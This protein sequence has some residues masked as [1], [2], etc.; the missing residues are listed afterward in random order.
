MP[1]VSF[2]FDDTLDQE[3]V[4]HYALQLM[5]RGV[6][7]WIVTARLDDDNV[8]KEFGEKIGNHDVIPPWAGNDDI[9]AQADAMGIPKNR[10]VFTNL[11]GKG[12]F[13]KRHPDFAW[14]LDDSSKQLFD[15][16][17]M[18]KVKP[19]SVFNPKWKQKCEKHLH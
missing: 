2:D 9:Y 8:M 13:F 12:A 6:E 15:V 11:L 5:D 3:E 18:S 7:V 1:R 14:H 4:W 10:I 16:Q 17:Y 19:I